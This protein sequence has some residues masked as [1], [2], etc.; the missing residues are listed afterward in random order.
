MANLKKDVVNIWLRG[1]ES[2]YDVKLDNLCIDIA[3]KISSRTTH[4]AKA[5][6][7][8]IAAGFCPYAARLIEWVGAKGVWLSIKQNLPGKGE[9]VHKVLSIVFPEVFY[10]I[11]YRSQVRVHHI[12]D[13]INEKINS[14]VNY[15]TR[16]GII[17]QQLPRDEIIELIRRAIEG[18]LIASKQLGVNL[19]NAKVFTETQMISYSFNLWGV[20]DVVI[21]DLD[22]KRAIIIEWKTGSPHVREKDKIQVY[23]YMLLELERLGYVNSNMSLDE[24]LNIAVATNPK[25][26]IVYPMIVRTGIRSSPYYSSYP[27]LPQATRKDVGEL[28]KEARR[29]IRKILLSSHFISILVSGLSPVG[30]SYDS[31]ALDKCRIY[32]ASSS[33]KKVG[34][35]A[36]NF[37]PQ[38]LRRFGP[39]NCELM[40]KGTCPWGKYCGVY[41][42]EFEHSG[43]DAELWKFRYR[44]ITKH[45][46]D[47]APYK[48]L[49][50]LSYRYGPYELINYVSRGFGFQVTIDMRDIILSGVGKDDIKVEI[51]QKPNE[52]EVKRVTNWGTDTL[53]NGRI[54]VFELILDEYGEFIEDVLILRRPFRKFEYVDKDRSESILKIASSE[55]RPR[56]VRSRKPVQLFAIEPHVNQLTMMQ[57][58]FARVDNV[59]FNYN[60]REIEVLIRPISW[61]LK[62]PFLLFKLSLRRFFSTNK[63]T[64]FVTEVNADLTHIELE[65]L[66]S[67]HTVMKKIS[68]ELNLSDENVQRLIKAIKSN[69]QRVLHLLTGLI[70]A[71][72]HR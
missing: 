30:L 35:L 7:V 20:P 37:I 8:A 15:L 62:L 2:S 1:L 33:G 48:L 70:L 58:I 55:R 10:N 4:L 64:I 44:V 45:L 50:E 29:Y 39:A 71:K 54:D 32:I 47:L 26:T 57:N 16:I 72:S 23:V 53:F 40:Q 60:R 36:F 46:R 43:I 65:A 18:L 42:T 69:K 52:F 61:A 13:I 9:D 12:R 67:L 21:E 41:F 31:D 6:S 66:G 17:S 5:S 51:I 59:K 14:A 25:Q 38:E 56:T 22:S 27:S 68:K 19:S 3:Y 49:Y 24:L 11:F 34:G 63:V 28:I